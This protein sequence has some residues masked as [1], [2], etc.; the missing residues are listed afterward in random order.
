MA[1]RKAQVDEE[2]VTFETDAG[3]VRL[4]TEHGLDCAEDDLRKEIESVRESLRELAK[5][6][7]RLANVLRAVEQGGR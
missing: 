2:V 5:I 4:I 6:V 7:E 1:K 3:D